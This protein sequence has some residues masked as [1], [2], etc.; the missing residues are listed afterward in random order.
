MGR[1]GATGAIFALAGVLA[2]GCGGHTAA[3]RSPLIA[4][5]GVAAGGAGVGGIGHTT[6]AEYRPNSTF[7]LAFVVENRS[8]KPV[9]VVGLSSGDDRGTRFAQLVGASV[10]AYVPPDCDGHSC[11]A[12]DLGLGPPPYGPLPALAALNIPA[13]RRATVQLHFRWVP[14]T[15]APPET[16]DTEN[17]TLLVDYRSEGRV[18]TQ[19]LQ[20]GSARLDVSSSGA[21]SAPGSS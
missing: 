7:G 20:T 1:T 9:T 8:S 14:C 12:P 10:A 4:S 3:E 17:A 2:A 16:N 21:C 5:G 11:P 19:H 6:T 15:V 18:L 13:H